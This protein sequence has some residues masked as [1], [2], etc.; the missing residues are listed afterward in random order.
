MN[1][2]FVI[3]LAYYAKIWYDKQS[4]NGCPLQGMILRDC[5]RKGV[6]SMY[7]TYADLFQFVI[8]LTGVI[9][10]VIGTKRKK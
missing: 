10:L 9:A 2:G 6:M 1:I 3:E 5:V 7:V 4:G 8:M